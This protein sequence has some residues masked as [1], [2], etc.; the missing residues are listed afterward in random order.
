MEIFEI[1]GVNLTKENAKIS[2]KITQHLD[3]TK[4]HIT[5]PWYCWKALDE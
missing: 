5:A 4:F 3:T 1:F 2:G